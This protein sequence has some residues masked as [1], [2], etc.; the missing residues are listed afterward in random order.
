MNKL[1][2]AE[3]LKLRTTRLLYGTIPAAVAISIAAVAGTVLSGHADQLGSAEGIRRV[4]SV[5]GAGAIVVLVVG[6]LIATG[7]FRHGTAV[8]TLLT[9]PRRRDVVI[10]KLLISA[11]LGFAVGAI[12]ALAA[13]GT[14]SL[15]YSQQGAALPFARRDVWL[16]L[17]GTLA[18]TTLF[19]VVGVAL[20]VL[21]RNQVFAVAG[22]LAWIAIVEHTL[23]N[24]APA[25]GRWL[26]AGAGQA[27][28]R[29]PID[30]LLSPVAGFAA[31]A[32]Y[33]ALIA[34]VG[35]R[36]DAARDA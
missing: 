2:S 23:V 27:I 6:I 10:A 24:L 21:V 11:G 15:L 28:V 8:D 4:F 18:Y 12:T 19:A 32:A 1:V 36:I 14:A 30:G 20:G 16:G 9:T 26:P 31:L 25:V 22:S 13:I 34:V 33:A 29:T 3:W 7:E 5:T 17:S 35:I